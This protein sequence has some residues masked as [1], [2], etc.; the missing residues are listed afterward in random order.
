MGLVIARRESL[1]G[2]LGT[3]SLDV[4]I[5]RPLGNKRSDGMVRVRLFVSM[6][7]EL[8]GT[9]AGGCKAGTDTF[10]VGKLFT[11]RQT[12]RTDYPHQLCL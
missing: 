12:G 6:K 7:D 10:R 11:L 3:D 2:E 8:T 5:Y 9:I 4:D 1:L